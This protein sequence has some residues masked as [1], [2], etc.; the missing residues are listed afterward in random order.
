MS[1]IIRMTSEHLEEI[2]KEFEKTLNGLKLSDGKISFTKVFGTIQKKTTLY[3]TETAYLKMITLVREFDNEVAWHGIAKRYEDGKNKGYIVSDILV[4]PQEVTGSTVTTDQEKYQTWLMNHDDEVFDNIRMQ[5]HS[6]V[7]MS[8][9]P[10]AV[11][12]SLYDRILEQM[13]DDMFYIF[14]IWNKK[15][16]KTIKIYDLKEN[17]L[18]ETGD[19]SV[20]ILDDGTGLESFLRNAKEMVQEKSFASITGIVKADRAK[21]NKRRK[22]KKKEKQN[23]Y[24]IQNS[25]VG[26]D[27]WYDEYEDYMDEYGNY[28]I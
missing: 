24:N 21:G 14:L 22:T 20:K 9:T 4:Y 8:T 11:D 19:I 2:R 12:T 28:L 1:K 17:V 23:V 26:N 16:E 13:D 15:G 18:Y 5:G 27:S 7:N 10:S 25:Y 6:H 3:F